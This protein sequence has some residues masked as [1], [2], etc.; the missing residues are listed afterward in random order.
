M[1]ILKRQKRVTAILGAGVNLSFFDWCDNTPSTAN[2]T[3]RLVTTPEIVYYDGSKG[4]ISPLIRQVYERLCADYPQGA[5][6]PNAEASYGII[7]FERIFHVLE[8][9]ES[10]SYVWIYKYRDFTKV[11]LFAYFTNPNFAYTPEEL[12]RALNQMT[13]IIMD[14]VNHYDEYYLTEKDNTCAWYKEFWQAAPFKWDVFNFNYDTTIENSITVEDGFE[15][16]VNYKPLQKFNPTKLLQSTENTIN[17]IHGC[18]LY[19]YSNMKLEDENK[20]LYLRNSHDWYKWPTFRESMGHFVGHG[21]SPVTAQNGD[22][23]YHSPIITGLNKTDK[24]TIQPFATYR[25]HLSHKISQNNALIIAGFSFGDYYVNLELEQLR[26][27]HGNKLRVVLID[28][29]NTDSHSDD[30]IFGMY[31][32]LQK[33]PYKNHELYMFLCKV[34]NISTINEHQYS[35]LISHDKPFISE[36]KQLMLFVG[37]M[38][39][40][41]RYKDEIYAFLNS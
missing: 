3:K 15:D 2:I 29:W 28:Y 35:R 33:L 5:L 14:I 8:M 39:H 27:L 7:H 26:L 18:L 4:S 12:H 34:M 19:S 10:Y 21:M 25:Y 24:L 13:Y 1:C 38:E 23:I 17:H 40:A 6:D 9:L 20:E 36:N 37:G 22:S 41:L 16:V 31:T 32:F 30:K 11:P